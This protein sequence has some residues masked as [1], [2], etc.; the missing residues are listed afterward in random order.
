MQRVGLDLANGFIKVCAEGQSPLVYENRLKQLSEAELSFMGGSTDTTYEVHGE[1]YQVSNDG[2]SSGGRDSDRY[3][4]EQYLVECLIALSRVATEPDVVLCIGLP[5]RDYQNKE[6]RQSIINLLK[7]CYEVKVDGVPKIINIEEVKVI[8]EPLGTLL[9][10]I[11]NSNLA[12]IGDRDQYTY[13]TI[14]I[15]YGTTDLLGTKQGVRPTKLACADV[16]M[17]D[18]MSHYLTLINNRMIAEGDNARFNQED[19]TLLFKSEIKKYG[20]IYNFEAELDRAKDYTAKLVASRI[21][22][23]GVNLNDYDRVIY[24][25]GGSLALKD[26]LNKPHNARMTQ[27]AQ[28]GN[29]EGYLRYLQIRGV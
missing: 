23:C 2:I 7:G 14:D 21:K 13:L 19:V 24:T 8:Y 25:G 26:Y 29:S 12:V 15:G 9:T 1:L 28:T 27:K 22:Q 4:T 20:R 5:G 16:G 11:Y 18:C 6:L 17:M 10:V 3:L